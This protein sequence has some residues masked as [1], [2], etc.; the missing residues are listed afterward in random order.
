[1]KKS[2]YLY[3]LLILLAISLSGCATAPPERPEE[4]DW[5]SFTPDQCYS[6]DGVYYALQ[7]VEAFQGMGSW[8]KVSIYRTDSGQ[9]V[10][11]FIP[12]RA[13][14]FWGICWESDSYNIW[15][16]SGDTGLRCYRYD[17]GQWIEDPNAVRPRDIRSK[18]DDLQ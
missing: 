17:A 16:Q 15:T 7:T 12:D 3:L 8:V 4:Q 18:Y 11:S 6:H 10:Y 9:P 14:D 5:G 13:W 1:M 2:R